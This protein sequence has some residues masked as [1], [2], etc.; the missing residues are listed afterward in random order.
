HLGH[1]RRGP[2]GDQVGHGRPAALG[3]R[4]QRLRPHRTAIQP[5]APRRGL[6]DRIGKGEKPMSLK[7]ALYGS[8]FAIAA[9]SLVGG[10]AYAQAGLLTGGATELEPITLS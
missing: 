2:R 1:R 8:V 9:S 3:R 5:P 10:E 7:H 4:R 6:A